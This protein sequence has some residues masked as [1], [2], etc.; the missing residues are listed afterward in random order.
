MTTGGG[1]AGRIV[2]GVDGS[3]SSL[4]ALRWAIGHAR[5]TGAS[6]EAVTAWQPPTPYE[7]LPPAVDVDFAGGAHQILADALD[8]AGGPQPGVPVLRQVSQGHP[9]EVLIAVSA[10]ADLLVLGCRG[11]RGF[12]SQLV[13][14]VSLHCVMRA[15]CPVLVVKQRLD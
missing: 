12:A 10:D 7:W 15:H 5:R 13:G 9:A 1:Y 6:V 8:A 3:D 14:S 2:A 4:D 11:R